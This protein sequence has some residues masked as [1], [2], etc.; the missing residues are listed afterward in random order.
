[1]FSKMS[2]LPQEWISGSLVDLAGDGMPGA[3]AIVS[4]ERERQ[5]ISRSG[6]Y[7]GAS[8]EIMGL[9]SRAIHKLT[10]SRPDCAW[11]AG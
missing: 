10:P 4:R 3:M 5:S 1:M 2:S 9:N 7:W 8:E 11:E 6:R